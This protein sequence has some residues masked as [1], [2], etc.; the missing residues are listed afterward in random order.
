MNNYKENL[1]NRFL[2]Y[3]SFD[4]QAKPNAKHSPSSAGQIKLAQYLQKELIEL[5]LQEV[6]VDRHAIVTAY[7]PSNRTELSH[8]IGFIAHLDTSPNVAAKM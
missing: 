2:H 4:T 7:L 6:N 5:G 8:T 1:L 3:V